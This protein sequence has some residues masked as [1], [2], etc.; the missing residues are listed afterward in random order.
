MIILVPGRLL[1][2][3]LAKERYAVL[4]SRISLVHFF[5]KCFQGRQGC[6]NRNFVSSATSRWSASDIPIHFIGA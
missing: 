2:E 4:L 5:R 6:K 3:A 1:S